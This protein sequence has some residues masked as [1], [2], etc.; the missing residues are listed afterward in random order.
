MCD[1]K[2]LIPFPQYDALKAEIQQLREE[3]S[4]AI[5][6][7]DDL[8]LQQCKNIEAAYLLRFG[9]LEYAAYEAECQYLR[10]KRKLELVIMKRN[11]QEP[12][13][14]Q[15]LE[16]ILDQEF[17]DY[18]RQLDALIQSMNEA[19][20]RSQAETLTEEDAAS[21]KSMYRK[22]V[23]ALHPDL[24]P[25]LSD[26]KAGLFSRAV[27]AY[28]D[29]NLELMQAI[30]ELVRQDDL[31]EEDASLLSYQK[32]KEQL[33]QKLQQVRARTAE[34]QTT[35]PYTLKEFLDDEARALQRKEEL[36]RLCKA[37]QAQA[38]DYKARIK[39]YLP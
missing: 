4:A 34:I 38:E 17:Q 3:L 30:F 14:I 19:L 28:Q 22:I 24:H 8:R 21:L 16:K 35:Y 33:V 11:R 20:D 32:E 37:Y 18:Q 5:L 7:Q 9:G 27:T 10:Y 39:E 13:D 29:G 31:H 36:E 15:A 26:A 12:V 25:E 2:K 1:E 23:K 6:E